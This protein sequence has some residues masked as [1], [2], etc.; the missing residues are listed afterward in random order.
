MRAAGH[1]GLT[2]PISDLWRKPPLRKK[3]APLGR[4]QIKCQVMQLHRLVPLFD[5]ADIFRFVRPKSRV[6]IPQNRENRHDENRPH[7]N[8]RSEEL[9]QTWQC[10]RK[11][12]HEKVSPARLPNRQE[13][14]GHKQNADEDWRRIF[15]T[16][17]KPNKDWGSDQQ[18]ASPL[19]PNRMYRRN[20]D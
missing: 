7:E 2:R 6:P 12:R 13:V 9:E 20:R 11:N 3:R 4:S 1:A 16:N 14:A 19:K 18:P 5:P 8:A 15:A 10:E 17:G